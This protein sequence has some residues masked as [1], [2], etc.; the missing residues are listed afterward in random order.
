MVNVNSVYTLVEALAN[1]N[2]AGWEGPDWF[3]AKIE[4]V[5]QELFRKYEL[6]VELD[7]LSIDFMNPLF[8]TKQQIIKDGCFDLPEDYYRMADI[9]VVYSGSTAPT[10]DSEIDFVLSAD[11]PSVTVTYGSFSLEEELASSVEQSM[12]KIPNA[13]VKSLRLFKTQEYSWFTNA[14]DKKG[15][16]K[17]RN[18]LK[19]GDPGYMHLGKKTIQIIPGDIGISYLQ[20]YRKPKVPKYGFTVNGALAVYDPST[21][22]NFDWPERLLPEIVKLMVEFFGITIRD[23]ELTTAIKSHRHKSI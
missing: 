14:S 6:R 8:C 20:Y 3:N 4:L 9:K 17:S 19:G 22:V 11:C 5:N 15:Y 1:K 7:Q 10:T 21:S 16:G 2:Q 23:A 18:P 13:S 12:I